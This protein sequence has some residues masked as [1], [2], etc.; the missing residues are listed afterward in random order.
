MSHVG[1]QQIVLGVD[2]DYDV[3]PANKAD[4]DQ[5]RRA[6]NWCLRMAG[7]LV[8]D[9]GNTLVNSKFWITRSPQEID[10]IPWPV[11]CGDCVTCRSGR[12]MAKRYIADNPGMSV[13][14]GLLDVKVGA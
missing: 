9:E 11:D 10:E 12:E 14:V 2:P 13:A 5:A 8:A 3:D 6:W 1:Q 7:E 4:R